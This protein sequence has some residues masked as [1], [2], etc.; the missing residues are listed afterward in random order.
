MK[1][2]LD[3]QL[4]SSLLIAL[5]SLGADCVHTSSLP[6]KN[7]T[8]DNE[9]LAFCKQENRIIISKDTDFLFSHLIHKN[10]SKLILICTGNIKNRDLLNLF[11]SNWKLITKELTTSNYIEVG[12]DYITIH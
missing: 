12:K 5:E 1:F 3:A 10:P 4:P 8:S 7:A 9:I 2:L 11:E 6:H